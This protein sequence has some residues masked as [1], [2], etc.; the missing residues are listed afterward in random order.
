MHA[1]DVATQRGADDIKFEK[2]S[3]EYVAR[4]KRES[5]GR[6]KIRVIPGLASLRLPNF[7]IGFWESSPA[8]PF[9]YNRIIG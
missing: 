9:N 1:G 6:R 5:V 4:M 3:P 2:C 7:L 8:I